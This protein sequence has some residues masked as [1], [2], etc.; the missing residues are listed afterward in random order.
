MRPLIVLV[1][2]ASTAHATQKAETTLSPY[3]QVEGGDSSL[4]ALPLEA[5]EAA[6]EVTGM[7]ANVTVKQSYKNAGKRPIHARYV[8]PA[9]TR[10]AVHG[11]RMIIGSRVVE[12]KIAERNEA[13]KEFEAAKREG[14]NASLLE[15]ERPNVF[16]MNVA[17][18]MPGERID[19]ELRYTELLVPT[20]GV[21]ELVYPAVVGPRYGKGDWQQSP[22]LKEGKPAPCRFS[23]SGH[24]ASPI[25]IQDLKLSAP[26]TPVAWGG[27]GDASFKIPD[28]DGTRDFILRYRL[29]GQK[30]QSGLMLHRGQRENFFLLMV[31]PPAQVTPEQ[32]PPREYVFIVDVSGSMHG[33][34][35]E[36]S[37]ELM[38]NL[39]GSLRPIDSFN[40]I[41]FS[42][43]HQ[44]MAPRSVPARPAMIDA[45]MDLIDRQSGGGGTEML[46]AIQEAMALPA[47][48]AS[49]TFVVVT[50]GFIFE[51]KAA[52]QHIRK[53]LDKANVFAFGI[54]SSVNRHLI[55][56]VAKAGYGEPFIV[57]K[58]ADGPAAAARFKLYV[59][60]PVLSQIKVKYE[61][62]KAF[63]FE[64]AAVP[65]LMARRPIVIH[66]KW[67]GTPSGKIVVEGT[68]GAGPYRKVIDLASAK[69]SDKYDALA[70]LWARSR[71]ATLSDFQRGDET[72]DEKAEITQLGL[73]YNLL[74]RH[75]S[76]IAVDTRVVNR[77]GAAKDVDQPVPLSENVSNYAVGSEPELMVLALALAVAALVTLRRRRHA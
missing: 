14:K 53:H 21:Y 77:E 58:P 63:D 75:T 25:P 74:T 66:G 52:F 6:I 46:P 55:E 67:A 44:L 36:V 15:E 68:S 76:F 33:F 28:G 12:A 32:I 8:F 43:A 51:E 59:E 26:T 49:R 11:M 4:D 17:N 65:D 23:I 54:G 50:D 2:F 47:V 31:E 34:P 1:L 39:L 42:G 3:F 69:T 41:L 38:R 27:P 7:I 20:D 56:G 71:I 10:A 70:Y 40:V 48:A 35:L 64:P 16:T 45:A 5:T 62:F 24:I 37:K 72:A 57:E 22:Y 19:V 9:S 13:K 60:A 30:I 18:L 61:D 73:T 29:A